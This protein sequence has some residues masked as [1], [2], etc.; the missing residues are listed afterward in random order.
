MV[1]TGNK[2]GRVIK[3]DVFDA[4]KDITDVKNFR[5]SALCLIAHIANIK[6]GNEW[7][8]LGES[9]VW[10]HVAPSRYA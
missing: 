8:G 2:D 5:K 4:L 6:R 9:R 3:F 1:T 7:L 10:K